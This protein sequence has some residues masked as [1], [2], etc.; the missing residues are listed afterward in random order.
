MLGRYAAE[1]LGINRDDAQPSIFIGDR[2][3]TVIGIID[4]VTDRSEMRTPGD[5]DRDRSVRCTGSKHRKPWRFA[6]EL[7]AAQLLGRQAALPS[8][9]TTRPPPGGCSVAPGAAQRRRLRGRERVVP[10]PAGASV[11]VSGLGI[12]NVTL[13]SVPERVPE[14]GCAQ[15]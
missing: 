3:F 10:G 13:L 15:R 2:T 5:A 14:I 12:A 6:T 4:G 8:T 11:L 7:G 1:R 9:R